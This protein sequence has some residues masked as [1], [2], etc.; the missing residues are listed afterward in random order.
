[1]NLPVK[2]IKQNW[3]WLVVS[4][5]ALLS[6]ISI[7]LSACGINSNVQN[8]PQTGQN[9]LQIPELLDSRTTPEITLV[10][11]NGAHEF[12]S[13]VQSETKGFNGDYLGPTIRL[14]KDTDATITF[15]NNIGEPTTVHG[16]GLHVNGEIDGGPQSA[17]QPGESW[18]ITI[19]VRQEAGTSWYH[20]HL[21]GKTA[22]H[23]HAGLAGLYL[24]ED[25]NSQ[26]LD[27]PKEY[28][29]NDIPLI[30]QD[31]SFTDGKMN[32]YAV[33]EDDIMN[34]L[35]EDTLV[36]NGTVDAYHPVP[37]GWVRLRLLNGSNARFYRFSFS[38]NVPFFKIA[39]E[40]GFLNQPVELEFIDMAPGE[41]NEIMIDLSD[42]AN[43]TLIADLLPAD[44]EDAG[45]WGVDTPQVNVVALQVDPTM[46]ASG[47]LLS[48]LN[49]IAYFDRADATQ[50][51]TFSLD[52]EVRGGNRDNV[53]M[54]AIN[55]RSMDMSYVNEH[56]KK[57][58]VEIWRIT[59]QRMPHP[60]HIHGASFQIL[61]HNGVPPA[62]VDRGWKDTVVVWDEVTEII[63]RF[64]YE[65]TEEF[66]YMY[67]CHMLEHE[68]YGM[69]GQFTVD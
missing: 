18:Q 42:G 10:M 59:A 31:R 58:E 3:L 55:G 61:T 22:H 25:E 29:V 27:L 16:H 53:N 2:W 47:T 45:F 62:E 63:V 40:G 23:V 9:P 65:A 8:A 24:I 43:A 4:L 33:T 41:R 36:V 38:N 66:P 44:P 64:D 1:M 5:L 12:Y 34:G 7:F 68:D 28:G 50:I 37:Q 48:T 49:D 14:Y 69:M 54:F 20:P 56:V 21:K 39:T 51:R 17:I 67:H 26:A 52:M 11:Q 35:R 19:P 13:G 30:V 15:I 46:Q 6:L 57:G 60:F 32:E